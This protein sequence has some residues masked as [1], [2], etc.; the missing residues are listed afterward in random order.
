MAQSFLKK[1]ILEE[2]KNVLNEQE[3][4]GGLTG[5]SRSAPISGAGFKG[6]SDIEKHFEKQVEEDPSQFAS[7]SKKGI[8]CPNARPIQQAIKN[9]LVKIPGME[10][11]VSRLSDD[12]VGPTT[13]KATNILLSMSG[14][15]NFPVNL[16]GYKQLCAADVDD[17]VSKINSVTPGTQFIAGMKNL[18]GVS[19]KFKDIKDN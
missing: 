9:K 11:I 17:V 8:K 2:I 5:Q 15:T 1:I 13:T 18:M 12:V 16:S 4:G 6:K 19:A 7:K 3:F 10:D 14:G